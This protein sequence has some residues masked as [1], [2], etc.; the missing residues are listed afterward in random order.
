MLNAEFSL[1]LPTILIMVIGSALMG[2]IFRSRQIRKK[3]HRIQELRNE[4]IGNHAH[5][6]ELEK[7]FVKLE[8]QMKINQAPV[9]PLKTS[10][11]D[12]MD[13]NQKVSEGSR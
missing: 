8:A 6:L 9:L 12:F 7:E 10:T 2:Y 5:I 11:K 3:Q 13:S 4:I 1:N